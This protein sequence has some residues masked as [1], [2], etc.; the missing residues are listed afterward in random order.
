MAT[1]FEDSPSAADK[2]FQDRYHQVLA[3]LTETVGPPFY[4][5]DGYILYH[6]DCTAFLGK[7]IESETKIDLSVT[8]PPYNLGMEY[9]K[10]HSLQD[11]LDWCQEWL[12]ALGEVSAENSGFWL[13]LGYLEVPGVG[14]AVPISYLLWDKIPF[15]LQQEIV[16][17]YPAGVACK[18]RFSPRNEKWLFYTKHS[19]DYTF[20]L[21]PVRDPNV[22]YPNQKRNGKFRC[23]P[24]GKNPGDVW[25]FPKVTGGLG[26]RSRERSAH[27]AQFPLRIIDRIVKAA[28]NSYDTVCDP[29]NGSGTAGIASIANRR[30]FIGCDIQGKYCEIARERVE[31]YLES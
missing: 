26:R 17:H 13:N 9:E 29:F 16:W 21:D 30:I 28:S 12:N 10:D 6:M 5:R 25:H 31:N 27:P 8:S 18:K 15:Y 3:D 23:N 19:D 2:K 14:K 7:L 11:Y 1:P 20:N 4:T 24:L 22:K